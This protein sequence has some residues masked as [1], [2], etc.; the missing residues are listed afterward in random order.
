MKAEI[1]KHRNGAVGEVELVFLR[2][3]G[4]FLQDRGV[5]AARQPPI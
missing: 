4:V 2:N 1:S 3:Q 5:S